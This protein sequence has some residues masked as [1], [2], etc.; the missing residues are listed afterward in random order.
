[1]AINAHLEAQV[2][3]IVQEELAALALRVEKLEG[4]RASHEPPPEE[5]K[6]RKKP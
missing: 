1:M 4:A 6:P 3:K 2:R 5:K